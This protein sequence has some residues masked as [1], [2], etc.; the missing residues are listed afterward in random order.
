YTKDNPMNKLYDR[1]KNELRKKGK[2]LGDIVVTG[3]ALI[4]SAPT[5]LLTAAAEYSSMA[6]PV[7][8]K[9]ERPGVNG[10]SFKLMKFRSMHEVDESK[11][12]TDDASRLTRVGKIIRSTSLDELPALINIIKGEMSLV[13]PRPLRVKYL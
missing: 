13:G 7:P 11:G 9:Q 3:P 5:Q 1:Y 4:V 2:R 8:S 12:L 6:K 10:I